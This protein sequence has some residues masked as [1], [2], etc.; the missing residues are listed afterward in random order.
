MSFLA[1]AGFEF[2]DNTSMKL[3][4]VIGLKRAKI[5]LIRMQT[6]KWNIFLNGTV[7]NILVFSVVGYETF[8]FLEKKTLQHGMQVRKWTAH[9]IQKQ[10]GI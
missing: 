5:A 1:H 3:P 8:P 6:E 2:S 7:R 4:Q 10:S 9:K